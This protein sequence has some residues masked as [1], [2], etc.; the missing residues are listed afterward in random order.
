[1]R[2]RCLVRCMEIPLKWKILPCYI[3]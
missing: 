2:S 1:M 3:K